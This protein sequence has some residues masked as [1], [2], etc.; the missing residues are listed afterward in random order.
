MKTISIEEC[1]QSLQ[2]NIEYFYLP[3]GIGDALITSRLI[4]SSLEYQGR[5]IVF[6]VQENHGVVLQ[7]LHYDNFIAIHSNRLQVIQATSRCKVRS[8]KPQCGKIYFSHPLMNPD[9]EGQRKL[10]ESG[11]DFLT[12]YKYF[13]K[14]YNAPNPLEFEIDDQQISDSVQQKIKSLTSC[15]LEKTICLYPHANSVPM[16]D[17]A[18][19]KKIYLENKSEDNF[20]FSNADISPDI[21]IIPLSIVDGLAIASKIS[22]IYAIRS[23]MCDLLQIYKKKLTVFYP[24]ARS[25]SFYSINRM[26]GYD[27][28]DEVLVQ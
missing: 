5:N 14:V 15:P 11:I 25:A 28:V 7:L 24:T 3:F 27:K 8:Y 13:Y 22:H 4:N 9:D 6:I 20:I 17:A 16:K 23:G 1:I 2:P 12:W 18:F 19:W 26:V 21:P 10:L